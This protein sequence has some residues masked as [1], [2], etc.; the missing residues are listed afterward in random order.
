LKCGWKFLKRFN[1]ISTD[2][3]NSWR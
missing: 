1:C 3:G 2:P